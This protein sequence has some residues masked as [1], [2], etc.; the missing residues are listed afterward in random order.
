MTNVRRPKPLSVKAA[1]KSA[2]GLLSGHRFRI[3]GEVSELSD[4]R[5]YKAVYFTIKD[6][7]ASLPCMMWRNRF[8]AAGVP[9]DLGTRV[10]VEGEFDIYA[11]LGRMSFSVSA[12]SREG[13]G[14]LRAR[15]A[16]IAAKLEAEGLMSA[17]K[18]RSLASFPECVGL[19]TSPNGAAV[20][21]VLRTMRRRCP[22]VRVLFAGVR[23]EGKDAPA[24]MMEGLRRVIEAGAE[25]VLLVRGGGS[26][27]NLM[28]FN[29]EA[30]ARFVATSP[31]PVITGIGH[32]RDTSIA[33]M[34]ADLRCATP[35]AAAEAIAPHRDDLMLSLGSLGQ[36][37]NRC[38]TNRL[39]RSEEFIEA[40]ASRPVMR[41]LLSLFATDTQM[42]DVMQASLERGLTALI[43]Q[44]S[45]RLDALRLRLTQSIP[46][47]QREDRF[48][49]E[50]LGARLSQTLPA[51]L[52]A[53][54]DS[55]D[56]SVRS[57]GVAM[58][59]NLDRVAVEAGQAQTALSRAGSDLVAPYE[60]QAAL[61]TA[62]LND[63]SPLRMLERGWSI[64]KDEAGSVVADV[65]AVG[66]G[67]AL[68]IQVR[69]GVIH[70][71]VSSS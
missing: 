62:R 45:E 30:L 40:R 38:F 66:P 32:E 22:S 19:V 70:A 25:E 33:D 8:N 43:T 34:V 53:E 23:V 15:V 9:L 42:T 4:K 1:V 10:I 5:G 13:E 31:V 64:V 56:A 2:Q 14:D 28:P 61:V 65:Q 18:K 52:A 48:E 44:R 37:A 27:E 55:L 36:R 54:Q 49:L 11:P 39:R 46:N 68:S 50:R 17:E 21:D 60:Q 67:D 51:R 47:A 57:L 16:R 6:E 26:F 71:K 12:L 7:S 58:R 20:H 59:L 24:S 41:D 63:L 69:D 3:V 29:D 35:T